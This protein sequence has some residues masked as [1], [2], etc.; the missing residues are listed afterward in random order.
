MPFNG[1][2]LRTER[3]AA[4]NHEPGRGMENPRH[5]GNQERNYLWCSLCNRK[6][7]HRSHA[8]FVCPTCSCHLGG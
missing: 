4:Y 2:A 7:P 8:T 3:S 6:F 1:F 5:E